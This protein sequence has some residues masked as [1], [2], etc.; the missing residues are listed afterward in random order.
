MEQRKQRRCLCS[1]YNVGDMPLPVIESKAYCHSTYS[2]P[3]VDST[4]ARVEIIAKGT[5]KNGTHWQYTAKCSGCTSFLA[6]SNRNTTLNPRGQNQLA[7]AWS[8]SKPSSTSPSGT[9][10]VHDNF[11]YI[12]PGVQFSLGE[13]QN[14]SW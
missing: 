10:N 8:A 6:Q 11:G 7:Y 14:W 9:I 4:R 3:A 12:N 13:N 1:L 2:P 5:K